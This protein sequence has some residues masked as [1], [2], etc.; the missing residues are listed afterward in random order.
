M[1]SLTIIGLY[2]ANKNTFYFIGLKNH[3]GPIW[4]CLAIAHVGG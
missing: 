4:A 2:V 1:K 3:P